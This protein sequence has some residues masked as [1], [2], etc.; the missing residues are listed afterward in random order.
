MRQR[1][2][3]LFGFFSTG[4]C[5]TEP[6]RHCI[7]E[8]QDVYLGDG[9]WINEGELFDASCGEPAALPSPNSSDGSSLP[10]LVARVLLA[11]DVELSLSPDHLQEELRVELRVLMKEPT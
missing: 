9:L 3:A 8:L 5:R 1:P 7:K 10:L 4:A 2:R 11:N 6:S